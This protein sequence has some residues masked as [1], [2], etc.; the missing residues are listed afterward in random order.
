MSASE[1]T[2]RGVSDEA[3][4]TVEERS[5][6]YCELFHEIPTPGNQIVHTDHQGIGGI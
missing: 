5:G 4:E 3:R 1:K 2:R 6:G